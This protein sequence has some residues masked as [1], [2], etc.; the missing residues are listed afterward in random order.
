MTQYQTKRRILLFADFHFCKGEESCLPILEIKIFS[1]INLFSFSIRKMC[2]HIIRGCVKNKKKGLP[3]IPLIVQTEVTMDHRTRQSNYH[4]SHFD[5]LPFPIKVYKVSKRCTGMHVTISHG[6][7][8]WERK[9]RKHPFRFWKNGVGEKLRR[10]YIFQIP[11]E[12]K[13]QFGCSWAFSKLP[14]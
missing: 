14:L 4:K 1:K 5:H 7:N 12:R 3:L 8:C 13:W 2:R 6:R 11:T 10:G 9:Q